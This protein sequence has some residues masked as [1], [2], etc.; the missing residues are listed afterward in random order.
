MSPQQITTV[1]FRVVINH[2]TSAVNVLSKWKQRRFQEFLVK[3]LIEFSGRAFTVDE[4]DRNFPGEK[5]FDQIPDEKSE[6]CR[7]D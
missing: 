2:H 4:V 1:G 5:G 3:Y 6:N 7:Q